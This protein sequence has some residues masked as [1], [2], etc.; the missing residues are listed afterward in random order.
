MLDLLEANYK[1]YSIYVCGGVVPADRSW[2]A[3][4]RLWPL[5][6]AAQMLR[7]D[8]AI[9]LDRW[10]LCRS[11]P[12]AS[13]SLSLSAP[14]VSQPLA[15]QLLSLSASAT[16]R[17]S[18]DHPL[19]SQASRLSASQPAASEPLWPQAGGR[20]SRPSSYRGSR[21]ARASL[22]RGAGRRPSL[23]TTTLPPI[24]SDP[25]PCCSELTS[26]PARPTSYLDPDPNPNPNPNPSPNPDPDPNPNPNPGPNP[27]PDPDPNPNPNQAR[28]T[29]YLDP[30]PDPDH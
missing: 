14:D 12:L 30:N 19:N 10:A 23:P 18:I 17:L 16:L 8:A 22:P 7:R 29:S 4:Y 5:G 6:L 1:T 27:D 9:K 15:S 21:G 13:Y 2:E 20:P 28:P 25:T 3:A 26:S 24:R 11:A